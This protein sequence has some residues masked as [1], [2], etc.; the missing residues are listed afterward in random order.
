MAVEPSQ[1]IRT[2][3]EYLLEVRSEFRKV[4]WP[5][6]KEYTGGTIGVLV[7]VAVMTLVLGS[8]DFTLAQL[9]DWLVPG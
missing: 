2:L 1:W 4:T 5:T 6:Q 7:I 8:V 3:R 9:L